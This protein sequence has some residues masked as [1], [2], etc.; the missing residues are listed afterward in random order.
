MD[1]VRAVA[2]LVRERN[3]TDGEIARIINRPAVAGHL[4]EWLASQL[5]DI[6]LEPSDGGA[7]FALVVPRAPAATEARA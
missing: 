6:D 3:E 1:S 2:R 5:L 7:S 4:G